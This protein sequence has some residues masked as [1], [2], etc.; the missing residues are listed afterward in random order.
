MQVCGYDLLQDVFPIYSWRDRGK[1]R[2]PQPRQ[3]TFG[4]RSELGA[5][6][7]KTGEVTAQPGWTNRKRTET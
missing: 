1:A 2:K 4:P 5:P 3:P 7:N 6:E